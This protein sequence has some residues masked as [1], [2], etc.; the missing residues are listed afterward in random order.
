MSLSGC[1]QQVERTNKGGFNGG[2]R[3]AEQVIVENQR[4][5]T[6]FGYP[7]FSNKLLIPK[8][9]P[10]QFH[11]EKDHLPISTAT[12]NYY[13]N[14]NNKLL[15]P[16]N[17]RH[18][19][20]ASG[21]VGGGERS[22]G[23]G[24]SEVG[25]S[26]SGS[27]FGVSSHGRVEGQDEEF[28]WFVSMDHQGQ[29]DIDDQGWCYSWSFRSKYWKG[30]N[31]FVR[32][33]FWIRLPT[34]NDNLGYCGHQHQNHVGTRT[35]YGR[36]DAVSTIV[37]E[38]E[39]QQCQ[40]EPPQL[41]K[42]ETAV[43]EDEHNNCNTSNSSK[44]NDSSTKSSTNKDNNNQE[45]EE[46]DAPECRI[47]DI[48]SNGPRIAQIPQPTTG[49]TGSTSENSAEAL[50]RQISTTEGVMSS[51][52]GLCVNNLNRSGS[53]EDD[54]DDQFT[55]AI[56]ISDVDEHL[57][58]Y[59]LYHQREENQVFSDILDKLI[60][61]LNNLS[62]DRQK[63]ELLDEFVRDKLSSINRQDLQRVLRDPKSNFIEQVLSSLQFD[64]SRRKF[65]DKWIT[66][67]R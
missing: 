25:G 41:G 19:G 60:F 62:L 10:P 27:T 52:K 34:R 53:D 42:Q 6:V 4:G 26:S 35:S 66:G 30:K 3:V 64:V 56:D 21:G 57:E 22:E 17:F 58:V 50:W 59:K 29:Y 47:M 20:F 63:L 54:A 2:L 39:E 61:E 7:F 46:I 49:A 37:E 14:T 55:D 8:V 1:G 12:S 18:L 38:E 23:E 51:I 5:I 32:K 13:G 67:I 44:S 45:E 65:L 16:L 24:S 15:L 40:I 28:A 48:N 11:T 9:D 36:T 31:G 43:L 33:R